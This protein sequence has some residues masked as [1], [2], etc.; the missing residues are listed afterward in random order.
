MNAIANA[1]SMDAVTAGMGFTHMPA[2][3]VPVLPATGEMQL[4]FAPMG[5][6]RDGYRRFL[7]R[8]ER[9][10]QSFSQGSASVFVNK[11]KHFMKGIP[12]QGGQVV[13]V[14]RHAL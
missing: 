5:A 13:G 8:M 12:L 10:P 14:Q 9:E 7:E 1:I 3:P 6:D 11:L 2:F 4:Q